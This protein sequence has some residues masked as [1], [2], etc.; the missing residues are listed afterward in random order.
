MPPAS[1]VA[2]AVPSVSFDSAPKSAELEP[3]LAVMRYAPLPVAA[4]DTMVMV[5][6]PRALNT[7]VRQ[8]FVRFHSI[9]LGAV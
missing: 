6:R 1:T 3:L 5:S 4:I 8:K 9:P 7:V 2:L